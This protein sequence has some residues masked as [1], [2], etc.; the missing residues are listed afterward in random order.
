MCLAAPTHPVIYGDA[1]EIVGDAPPL[2]SFDEYLTTLAYICVIRMRLT[3]LFISICNVLR[4]RP[5]PRIRLCYCFC[6]QQV[7]LFSRN[8]ACFGVK[9]QPELHIGRSRIIRCEWVIS[10]Y[11]LGKYGLRNA[12]SLGTLQEKKRCLFD[13]LRTG[14]VFR[15]IR[16]NIGGSWHYGWIKLQFNAVSSGFRLLGY[17]YDGTPNQLI[18]AADRESSAGVATMPGN[19]NS[20]I[21][22]YP[23]PF[24]QSTT[25][26]F[27]SNMRGP[28]QV[29]IVNLLGNPVSTLFDGELDAGEHSFTWNANVLSPGMYD[30]LIRVNGRWRRFR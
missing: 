30:C 11:E 14:S 27:S 19:N 22:V 3:P 6:F 23:N 12:G 10:N 29:I 18:K 28:V 21:V 4:A 5:V 1:P 8:R 16:V 13:K 9:I 25:I 2:S 26:N 17:C 20:S 15:R 24:S 7:G